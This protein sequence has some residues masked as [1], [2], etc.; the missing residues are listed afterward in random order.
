MPAMPARRR[1]GSIDLP[2]NLYATTDRASG[3]TYYRYKDIRTG[4]FHGMG[5]D[6]A[7]AV[8]DARALNAA[9]LAQLAGAR[10]DAIASAK[11]SGPTLGAV[12]LKHLEHCEKLQAKGK[13]AAN[14][15]KTKRSIGNA[16][17]RAKGKLP[18]DAFSVRDAVEILAAY[19]ESDPPRERMALAVRSEGI[20]IFKTAIAE[21]LATD[22][23]FA[24]TRAPTVFVKRARLV[25]DSFRQIHAASLE[26]DSPWIARSIEL[27][28]VTGQRREDVACIE[29]RPRA[30][31][32][33]W[34]ESG[35]LYVIQHKTG[36]RVAIPLSLR[37]D[38][39]GL[40]LGEIIA[41]CRDAVVSRYAVHHTRPYG[42][43][44]PGDDVFVDT[45][46]RRFAEAR[47]L[48]ASRSE[49]PLWEAGKT[50]PTFHELRS[51]AE[52]LY[53]DQ[54]NVNTQLLLGHKDPRSTA[55][56]KDA[57]GAEW[58]RVLVG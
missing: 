36:N 38:V 15:L 24:K 43:C 58:M 18:I 40:E 10:V 45:L 41:S 51:L 28:I 16:I 50:P 21:G 30:G 31:A 39:L 55:I 3:R 32:T 12:I 6:K 5:S 7:A 53:N 37:L 48:A 13:L 29:F 46:T 4:T 20:E 8:K 14:T 25:L 17:T 1:P 2:D 42:N 57:R 33:A 47:D 19:L 9:I 35:A 56:Y 34:I 22:N 26:L 54:G 49:S 27:G 52:R 44:N 23:P 11:P